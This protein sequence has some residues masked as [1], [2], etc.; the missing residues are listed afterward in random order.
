MKKPKYIGPYRLEGMLGRGGM[1]E[2]YRAYDERLSRWVAIKQ[3]RPDREANPRAQSRL[4]REARAVARLSH[5]AI[6]QVFDVLDTEEGFWIVMELVDGQT[7]SSLIR[8][9]PID[10]A[11]VLRLGREIAEGLAHAPRNGH[12]ASR[13]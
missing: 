2:V 11:V 10:V 6:V 5:P 12:R 3:V 7:L 9:G 4:K 8:E 1:G 13:S